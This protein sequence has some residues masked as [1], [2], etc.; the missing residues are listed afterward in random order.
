MKKSNLLFGAVA[1]LMV[2]VIAVAGSTFAWFS[3]VKSPYVEQI[4]ATVVGSEALLISTKLNGDYKDRLAATDLIS[5]LTRNSQSQFQSSSIPNGQYG[6][7]TPIATAGDI[8]V[9]GEG[10]L[11]EGFS[12]GMEFIGDY[13]ATEW[14]TFLAAF[15][16]NAGAYTGFDPATDT[17]YTGTVPYVQAK[18][19][20]DLSG[21][22]PLTPSDI[23]NF[24]ASGADMY[25]AFDPLT[26]SGYTGTV[27][28]LQAAAA[29]ENFRQAK[30][31]L[32]RN[33]AANYDYKEASPGVYEVITDHYMYFPLFFRANQR[34]NVYLNLATANDQ[35]PAS[36]N[37]SYFRS[38]LDTQLSVNTVARQHLQ[39]SLRM[40]YVTGKGKTPTPTVDEDY[41][42]TVVA[43][44]TLT[45]YE[46]HPQKNAPYKGNVTGGN[47]GGNIIEN[48]YS[49]VT[50]DDL[51][52]SAVAP[53]RAN[54]LFLGT[55]ESYDDT[56]ETIMVV[57]FYIWID[58]NDVSCTSFAAG[59][60]FATKL[61]FIG[62]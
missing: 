45:V 33:V 43:G 36:L 10:K 27:P 38:D 60:L 9:D 6:S 44:S 23:T 17:G 3:S 55:C 34:M 58:G 30:L 61:Q 37:A 56:E 13:D 35:T 51:D 48:L 12:P 49:T 50:W 7:V 40:G 16:T 59:G 8:L 2:S 47:S 41:A 57:H 20:W 29:W 54:Q 21:L 52:G 5:S 4:D 28:Y 62:I 42:N 14:A 18:A 31:D 22:D 1:M 26:A 19:A 24:I 25:T 46:P 32:I 11:I 15:I 39:E 53:H